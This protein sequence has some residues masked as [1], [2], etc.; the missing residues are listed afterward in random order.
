MLLRT[1]LGA[2]MLATSG[3]LAAQEPAPAP[4]A[5]DVAARIERVLGKTPLVDG[6]NDLPHAVREK[7]DYSVADLVTAPEFMTDMDRL[8]A[9]H[10]G[11]Q[12][13]SVYIDAGITGDAAIRAT[14]EQIDIADRM[15]AAYP[16]RLA[17]ARTAD[18]IE[19]IH[20]SGRVASLVGIEGG[21][22]IGGSLA[23][24]R[25]FRRLGAIYMTLTHSKT[26]GWAD[27]ATDEARHGGLAPFGEAVVREMNRIGMLVDLSHVSPEAMHDA[28]DIAAAPVI[29]SHSSARGK[30]DHVR[31]V[32][33][34]VLA[35]LKDN[36]GV[37]MVTFVPGF[38]NAEAGVWGE[39]A[40][41]EIKRIEAKYP[42]GADAP[43]DA[44]KAEWLAWMAANPA[45]VTD[46]THVAD[47]V[48]H[49]VRVAG[50]DHVG[51]GG[52]LDGIGAAPVGLDSVDDYPNLFAE[53]IRRGWNDEDL[54]KLAG[55]NFLRALRGAEAVATATAGTPAPLDKPAQA[56]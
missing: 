23:A 31:N 35:R 29:F 51:I 40:Q 47:H 26:T 2:L 8:A 9:G 45:P 4:I 30:T 11:A 48:E 6:H 28:L 44:A 25:Q 54:A 15:I 17:W 24:L 50:I 1:A 13:W 5:S 53:L 43:S 52:D 37:V 22:Q 10:V 34:D 14:I 49:V 21:H 18:E 39:A 41:A 3:H 7:R 20:A 42:E 19:A 36:G 46:V 55:G 56:D 27:S 38:V 12:L 16:D 32:P 33:D